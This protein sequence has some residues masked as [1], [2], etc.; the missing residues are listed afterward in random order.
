MNR[1]ACL[2][3]EVRKDNVKNAFLFSQ[4]STETPVI[5]AELSEALTV[6]WE[7]LLIKSTPPRGKCLPCSLQGIDIL[8]RFSFLAKKKHPGRCYAMSLKLRILSTHNNACPSNRL[9]LT[10]ANLEQAILPYLP[11][12]H[13]NGRHVAPLGHHW[14]WGGDALQTKNISPKSLIF[15]W[16]PNHRSFSESQSWSWEVGDFGELELGMTNLFFSTSKAFFINSK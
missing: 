9:I 10:Q 12:E 15:L 8:D 4:I 14:G 13:W 7:A 16:T 5:A 11:S 1:D 6:W 3:N 2:N